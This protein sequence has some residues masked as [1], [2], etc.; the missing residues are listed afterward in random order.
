MRSIFESA[1]SILE[2]T[3]ASQSQ[4]DAL[5]KVMLSMKQAYSSINAVRS[6]LDTPAGAALL[7]IV[8]IIAGNTSLFNAFVAEFKKNGFGVTEETQIDESSEA[9][10]FDKIAGIIKK[11][12][13]L[14]STK[15]SS[16]FEKYDFGD[17]EYYSYGG[18]FDQV[19]WKK[20]ADKKALDWEVNSTYTDAKGTQLRYKGMTKNDFLNVMVEETD[21][22]EIQ[23]T[24]EEAAILKEDKLQND[25]K[26]LRKIGW[27]LNK[28]IPFLITKGDDYGVKMTSDLITMYYNEGDKKAAP[29]APVIKVPKPK[30]VSWPKDPPKSKLND[31][32]HAEAYLGQVIDSDE[33]PDMTGSEAHKVLT[34]AGYTE[35]AIMW[36]IRNF[37]WEGDLRQGPNAAKFAKK[38]ARKRVG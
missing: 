31:P 15:N 2:K 36:V 18:G 3:E 29:K 33:S 27:K 4:L 19:I 32:Q 30:K 23:L 11:K 20:S 12:G 25:I 34:Q 24:A 21:D 10:K 8:S 5:T 22:D 35:H 1:K 6:K 17:Y 16:D 38:T 26:S 9:N 37:G 28:I 13:K 7:D 14:V